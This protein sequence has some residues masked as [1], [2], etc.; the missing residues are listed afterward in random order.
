M[1]GP[2][3]PEAGETSVLV[4]VTPEEAVLRA[5]EA[6]WLCAWCHARIAKEK[7][8]LMI[9]GKDEFTFTNPQ[10]V[11]FEIITFSQTP[12]CHETGAPTLE[13]TWF[14]G[15]AWSFCHCDGCGQQL[16]WY[17]AGLLRFAGLDKSRIVRGFVN[18]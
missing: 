8:R 6:D 5:G 17:Y 9:D 18:N 4:T 15:Y 3:P 7:H 2:F 16:G 14:P 1:M 12:G 11:R 13:H 10:G